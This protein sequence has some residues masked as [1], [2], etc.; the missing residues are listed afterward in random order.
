MNIEY[1]AKEKKLRRKVLMIFTFNFLNA[2][3]QCAVGTNYSFKIKS[4]VVQQEAILHMHIIM[5]HSI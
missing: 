2:Q 4:I 1:R 5:T 3:P